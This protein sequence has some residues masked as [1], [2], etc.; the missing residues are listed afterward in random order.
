MTNDLQVMVDL[1]TL[2]VTPN[3]VICSI[4]AT[5]FSFKDGIIEKFYCTVDAKDCKKY[6]LVVSQETLNWWKSQPKEVFA[7]L[8]QDNLPLREALQRFSVWYGSKSL[9]TWGCG[10][11]FDNVI[12]Q[13]AYDAVEMRR[14]WKH[15]HDRCYRTMR[16][17]VVVEPNPRTGTYHNALDDAVYQTNHLI[18]IMGS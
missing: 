5:K 18:K 16:E 4:G 2:A 14:P 15:W 10:S 11:S 3:A 17:V 1:E 8:M 13:W 12:L 7:S 6:G 9:P